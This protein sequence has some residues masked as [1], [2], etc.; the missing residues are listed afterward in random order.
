MDG[1][2]FSANISTKLGIGNNIY[3]QKNKRIKR[4]PLRYV[5]LNLFQ[6]T[7]KPEVKVCEMGYW[8][9]GIQKWE[10]HITNS[11]TGAT[12]ELQRQELEVIFKEVEPKMDEE[13]SFLEVYVTIGNSVLKFATKD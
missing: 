8:Q 12:M 13:T 7:E 1:D 6:L 3:F 5:F 2:W 11:N 4:Q 10:Y 9:K